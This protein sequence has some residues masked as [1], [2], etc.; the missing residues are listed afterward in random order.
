M[1]LT[2]GDGQYTTILKGHGLF[3]MAETLNQLKLCLKAA[4]FLLLTRGHIINLM[5]LFNQCIEDDEEDSDCGDESQDRVNE[6]TASSP[7]DE[8][9]KA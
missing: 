8:Y 3:K 6:F 2:F 4:K 5:T 7:S 9:N 1:D